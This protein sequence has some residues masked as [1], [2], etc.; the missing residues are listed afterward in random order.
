MAPK[1]TPKKVDFGNFG[2]NNPTT[3]FQ[4][5]NITFMAFNTAIP[6]LKNARRRF[7][8]FVLVLEI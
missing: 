4:P 3:K 1:H 5:S 8:N 2:P 6:L 7:L